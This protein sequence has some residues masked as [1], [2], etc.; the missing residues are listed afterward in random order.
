MIDY[1]DS[2]EN[3]CGNLGGRDRRDIAGATVCH[4]CAH[5]RGARERAE[6]Q[7]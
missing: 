4:A 5:W 3:I 1:N 7:I 2:V 6:R